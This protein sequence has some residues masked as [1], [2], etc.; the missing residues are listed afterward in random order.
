MNRKIAVPALTALLGLLVGGTSVECAHRYHDRSSKEAFAQRMRC[1]TLADKYVRSNSNEDVS[2]TLQKVDYSPAS[3]TCFA[4]FETWISSSL[5]NEVSWDLVNLLTGEETPI[6]IC[7]L[8]Q[9][10]EG[11]NIHYEDRLDVAFKNAIDGT[12]PPLDL[13]VRKPK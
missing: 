6:G 8:S 1:R 13:P 2:V 9:C 12:V 11:P 10:G 4:G 7:N 3:N 5:G